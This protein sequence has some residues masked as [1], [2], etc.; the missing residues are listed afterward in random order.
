MHIFITGEVGVGK[1][2]L[3]KYLLEQL[4]KEKIYGF[5]TQKLSKEEQLGGKG[6]VY[7]SAAP[8]KEQIRLEHC[9]AEILGNRQ[10]N[11]YLEEFENYGVSLLEAIP[12]GSYV[13]M[14]ELGFLESK[15]PRFCSKVLE[16][17]DREIKILG[18][19]KPKKTEFL[20]T[21]RAHERVAIYSMTEENRT[22]LRGMLRQI[23]E[24]ES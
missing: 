17:L 8:Y 3:L 7:L 16:L 5:Y 23:L 9:V 13:L 21:V 15:A 20:D 1:T 6:E 22:V 14:D 19:I 4:P 10:F 18:V 12:D 11:L 24:R 2:T